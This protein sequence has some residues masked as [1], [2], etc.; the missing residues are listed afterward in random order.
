MKKLDLRTVLE[1]TGDTCQPV[2]KDGLGRQVFPRH[3]SRPYFRLS[4]YAVSSAVSG[5]SLILVPRD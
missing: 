4:D 2:G 1:V 3:G 5:P